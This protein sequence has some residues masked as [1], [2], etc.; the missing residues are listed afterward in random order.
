M[1][2]WSTSHGGTMSDIDPRA[3]EWA[4]EAEE[5]PADTPW[6]PAEVPDEVNDADAA[7]QSIDVG[8]DDDEYR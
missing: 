6:G 8:L 3:E 7:E 2:F 4:D 1:S 5:T